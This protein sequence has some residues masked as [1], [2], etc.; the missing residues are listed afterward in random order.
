SLGA[1]PFLGVSY[2]PRTDPGQFVINLKAPTGLRIE[3]TEKLVA[4]TEEIIREEVAKEDLG[5]IVANI[6]VQPGFSSIYTS[7]A[8]H[9]T[10]TIQVSLNEKHRVGSY[11][12]MKRVRQRLRDD[13]PQVTAYFQSGGLVDAVLNLG[14]PAP[15]DLQVNGSRLEET[16]RTAVDLAR[17][18]RALPGVSD[19]LVP[20]DIDYP[21]LQL[22]VD[23]RKASELGLTSKEVVHNV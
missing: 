3:S 7:N 5:V 22:D 1:Y 21:A 8:G 18:I 16:H 23:R 17:Q 4:R 2:F 19:V 11:A 20:Q 14:L 15:I 6:G 13:L 9:H 12:Y 10:A